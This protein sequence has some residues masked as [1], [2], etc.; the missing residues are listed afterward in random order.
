MQADEEWW[1]LARKEGF[2]IAD[3][4]YD[5]SAKTYSIDICVR[6][7]DDAGNFLGIIK[8]SLDIRGVIDIIAEL[9]KSEVQK[10]RAGH[11]AHRDLDNE[12]NM[13]F[14]LLTK[15]GRS[16]YSTTGDVFL[17]DQSQFA[18]YNKNPLGGPG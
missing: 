15:D 8:A 2:Y 11:R 7:D 6:I 5:E 4:K 9:E 17:K 12:L 14:D 10:H 1:Q 16:I 3:V 13:R 18:V